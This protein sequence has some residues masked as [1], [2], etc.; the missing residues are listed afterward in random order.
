M[1]KKNKIKVIISSIIIL[2]PA[3]L[4]LYFSVKLACMQ[5]LIP[6]YLQWVPQIILL[7]LLIT[8]FR[9]AISFETILSKV[10]TKIQSIIAFL[11]GFTLE[12][13]IV[14]YA[15]ILYLNKGRFP[16]NFVLVSA[17]ILLF[18]WILHI[19]TNRITAPLN[20]FV[21]TTGVPKLK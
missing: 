3:L 15:P 16:L 11:A 18:S 10:H 1:L 14:Q 13:Y 4:I 19:I 9:S 17:S 6:L 2:L 21:S 12:I 8:I 5:E 7:M 20:R